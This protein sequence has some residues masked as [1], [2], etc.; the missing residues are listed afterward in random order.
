MRFINFKMLLLKI[1]NLELRQSCSEVAIYYIYIRIIYYIYVYIYVLYIYTCI[2]YIICIY[3]IYIL[4]IHYI[5]YIYIFFLPTSVIMILILDS[6]VEGLD[7]PI[8]QSFCCVGDIYWR[9][10]VYL[11]HLMY[12]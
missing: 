11:S 4:Y 8:Y 6:Y 1:T 2:I 5:L 3:I 7:R 10:L 12:G 9:A